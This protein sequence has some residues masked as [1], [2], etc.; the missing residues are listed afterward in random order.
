M[1]RHEGAQLCAVRKGQVDLISL[2]C[3]DALA[4]VGNIGVKL[5]RRNRRHR[6]GQ[7]RLCVGRSLCI[8]PRQSRIF[9][10][11]AQRTKGHRLQ[12]RRAR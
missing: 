5:R 7:V 4:Y 3:G 12:H 1:V 6:C 2:S 9:V 11:Q 8:Q 10:Q